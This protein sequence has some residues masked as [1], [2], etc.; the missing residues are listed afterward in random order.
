MSHSFAHWL[1]MYVLLQMLISIAACADAYRTQSLVRHCTSLSCCQNLFQASC[2][3]YEA[4]RFCLFSRPLDDR[5]VGLSVH[6]PVHPIRLL[7]AVT[8]ARTIWRS[9]PCFGF[10]CRSWSLLVLLS[11]ETAFSSLLYLTFPFSVRVGQGICVHCF[12]SWKK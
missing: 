5:L 8:A 3:D 6:R 2:F 1:S 9:T 12:L 11:N 7:F 10:V 4:M